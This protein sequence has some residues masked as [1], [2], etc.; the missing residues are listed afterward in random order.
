M[1]SLDL[2]VLSAPPAFVLSQ[3]QTLRSGFG[4]L[5]EERSLTMLRAGTSGANPRSRLI[6]QRDVRVFRLC[7]RFVRFIQAAK[8][9]LETLGTDASVLRR[10]LGC[11]KALALLRARCLVLK[12]HCSRIHQICGPTSAGQILGTK[13]R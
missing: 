6:D 13:N 5:H 7:V 4:M 10:N 2:H 12:E 3:D 11:C 9:L 8:L 1:G